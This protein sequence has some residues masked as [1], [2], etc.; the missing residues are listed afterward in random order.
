MASR[1]DLMEKAD[2][3]SVKLGDLSVAIYGAYDD[4]TGAE[5]KWLPLFDAVAESLREESREAG[6][7]APA[8][9]VVLSAARHRHPGEYGAWR[10]AKREVARLEEI[11]RNRRAELSGV[12][13]QIREAG[14]DGAKDGGQDRRGLTQH[15]QRRAA[16]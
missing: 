10:K 5:E 11:A 13:T 8:E 6:R 14:P 12:Q 3:L 1:S 16:A 9:H 2:D 4:L 15:G 7:A